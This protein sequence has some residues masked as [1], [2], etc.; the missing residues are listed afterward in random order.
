MH[1]Y[2]IIVE[3]RGRTNNVWTPSPGGVYPAL[4]KLQDEGL[5]HSSEERGRKVFN[6]TAAG[7]AAAKRVDIALEPSQAVIN[8]ASD[9][10]LD[11]AAVISHISMAYVQVLQS[12]DAVI[13]TQA[14]QLLLNTRRSLYCLLAELSHAALTP[15]NPSDKT[16]DA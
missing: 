12:D 3:I 9:A 5:I 1:G 2:R 10:A 7:E 16:P 15:S 11:S 6:L 8:S 13:L 14:F 4:S